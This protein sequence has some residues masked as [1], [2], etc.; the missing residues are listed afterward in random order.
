[1][2]RALVSELGFDVDEAADGQQ[3]LDRIHAL[4]PNLVLMDAAMPVMD[5]LEATRRLR[6]DPRWRE[7]PIVIVSAAVSDHDQHRCREAGA[8]G[9]IAKPVDRDLLLDALQHGLGLRWRY[10]TGTA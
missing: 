4:T 5:G 10:A 2:L 8:S 9:F 3:A 6:A 1:M 7:L